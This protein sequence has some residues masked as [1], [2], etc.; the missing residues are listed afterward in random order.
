MWGSRMYFT[1]E[2]NEK[3]ILT[4]LGNTIQL[5]NPVIQKHNRFLFKIVQLLNP[6]C[7]PK[8]EKKKNRMSREKGNHVKLVIST[9]GTKVILNQ[10]II[11]Q[12]IS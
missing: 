5:L 3:W 2:E 8:S 4:F 11:R 7:N 1:E 9:M 6:N 12:D 10:V